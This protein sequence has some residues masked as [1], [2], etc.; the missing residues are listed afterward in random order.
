MIV[1]VILEAAEKADEVV[2]EET[3]VES[4]VEA[5]HDKTAGKVEAIRD[6]TAGGI[7]A[8]IDKAAEGVV[9]ILD[10]AA[11]GVEAGRRRRQ[12]RRAVRPREGLR[13]TV[14][15]GFYTCG[16]KGDQD[17]EVWT[18]IARSDAERRK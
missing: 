17:G 4:F 1:E 16:I 3:V 7:E 9:A 12:D 8:V 2:I 15:D 6:K 10:K 11:E 14:G 18:L 13:D 5:I